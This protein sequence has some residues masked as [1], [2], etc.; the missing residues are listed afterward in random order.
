MIGRGDHQDVDAG[1]VQ[2][3][4]KVTDKLWRFLLNFTDQFTRP[5]RGSRIDVADVGDLRVLC[6]HH[7]ASDSRCRDH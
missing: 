3:S 1:V 4:A 7:S 5:G 2:D 6:R